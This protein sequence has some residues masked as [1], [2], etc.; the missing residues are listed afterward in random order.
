MN[1]LKWGTEEQ[2]SA[3]QFLISYII[4]IWSYILYMIRIGHSNPTPYNTFKNMTHIKYNWWQYSFLNNNNNGQMDDRQNDKLLPG[5]S[6]ISTGKA[7]FCEWAT[8][9][10]LSGRELYPPKR[11]IKNRMPNLGCKKWFWTD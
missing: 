8:S 3:V 10:I 1:N 9:G 6:M 5:V 11:N 7:N 2:R 4:R